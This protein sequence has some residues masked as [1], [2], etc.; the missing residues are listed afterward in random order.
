MN[1]QE[2]KAYNDHVEQA[3][4]N[5]SVDVLAGLEARRLR[6]RQHRR[7]ALAGLALAT[8]LV[9]LLM[10]VPRESDQVLSGLNDTDTFLTASSTE[11]ANDMLEDF[12]Q[13][14]ALDRI[15]DAPTSRNILI[16]NNDIDDLL[17][18]L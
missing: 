14:A 3:T 11:I 10:V 12:A 18:D 16:T 13:E 6:R 2:R 5:L 17:K 4:R 7:T 9:L 1:E 15:V 8:C